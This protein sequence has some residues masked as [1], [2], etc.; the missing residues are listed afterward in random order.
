MHPDCVGAVELTGLGLAASVAMVAPYDFV[1][2][3]ELWR[4]VPDDTSVLLAR[5]RHLTLTGGVAQAHAIADHTGLKEL[6]RSVSILHSPVVGYLCTSASFVDGPAGEVKLRRLLRG[7]GFPAAV[8]TS[9]A[10]VDALHALSVHRVAVATPYLGEV[11]RLLV[12]FLAAHGFRVTGSGQ[13][14]MGAEIWTTEAATLRALARRVVTPD[15]EA[16]FLS[17]TNLPSYDQI[18]ILEDELQIPV[19]SANQ[20]TMWSCLRAAGRSAVGAGR[21]LREHP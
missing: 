5:T 19:L 12:D 4:W 7:A 10:L 16:L 18:E 11:T 2:D 9:G 14:E 6:A 17:C 1:L 8:T 3:R 15:A 21:L 13:L 20:V